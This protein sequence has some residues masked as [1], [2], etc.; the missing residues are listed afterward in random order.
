M[1]TGG[2]TGHPIGARPHLL[3]RQRSLSPWGRAMAVSGDCAS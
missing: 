3:K 2:G 1:G